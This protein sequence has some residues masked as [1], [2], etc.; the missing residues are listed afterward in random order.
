MKTSN[1]RNYFRDLNSSCMVSVDNSALPMRS[2][3]RE[4]LMDLKGVGNM[5]F[6]KEVSVNLTKYV[7]KV[8]VGLGKSKRWI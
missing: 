1:G 6:P 2:W 4:S 7:A 3:I 5:R 8:C